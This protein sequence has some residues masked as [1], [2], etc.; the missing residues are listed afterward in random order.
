MAM[1]LQL[2]K[3][4]IPTVDVQLYQSML[5]SLMY[6]AMGTRPNISFTVNTLAQHTSSPGE[7]H[8]RALKRIFQYLIGMKNYRLVFKG[9]TKDCT[10]VGFVDADWA[11]DANSRRSITRYVFFLNGTPVSWS[12]KK[13][14][15]ISLSSTE[16]E[17]MASSQAAHEA[18]YLQQFLTEIG[19][20]RK[21]PTPILIDNQLAIAIARNL[22][23][24]AHT[25][26]IE[27]RH[28]YMWEKLKDGIIELEYCPNADQTADIL[29]KALAL[30]KHL[31]FVKSLTL[32]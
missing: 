2:K 3:L 17:Y 20:R 30:V 21:D 22:E 29:T 16:S 14:P 4:D 25:K 12:A 24:H 1:N 15:S 31:K 9:R 11:G 13:Q 23:F 19:F 8:L 10:L 26:H 7:E 6:T 18:V 5:G 32:F 28:H 27:V